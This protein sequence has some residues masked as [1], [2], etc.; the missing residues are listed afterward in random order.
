MWDLFCGLVLQVILRKERSR[1]MDEK[2]KIKLA[3]FSFSILLMGVIGIAG[4]LVLSA[5]ILAVCPRPLFN[6]SFR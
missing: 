3:I 1:S 4:G 6:Y 5:N 2:G